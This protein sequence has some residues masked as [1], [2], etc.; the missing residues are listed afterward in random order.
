LNCF[1]TLIETASRDN[2]RCY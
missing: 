2:N 1:I